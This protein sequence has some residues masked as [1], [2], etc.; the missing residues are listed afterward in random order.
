MDRHS[1][2]AGHGQSELQYAR[3]FPYRSGMSRRSSPQRITDEQAFP[4]RVIL[5]GLPGGFAAALG[6]G[7]DPH[8]WMQEHIGPGEM[9]LYGWHTVYCPDGFAL[10][11][12]SCGDAAKF[13]AAFPEFEIADGTVMEIYNSPHI[14]NGRRR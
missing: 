11:A 12:R 9:A 13:L 2:R 4:V 6:P 5:R 7:R 10:F 3:V 1:G 14:T 8:R